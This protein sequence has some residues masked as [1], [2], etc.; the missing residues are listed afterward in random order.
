MARLGLDRV[1][2][3]KAVELQRLIDDNAAAEARVRRK[4][5]W[6]LMPLLCSVNST[7]SPLEGPPLWGGSLHPSFL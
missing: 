4:L 7:R 1:K 3:Q 2:E 5:D 6:H